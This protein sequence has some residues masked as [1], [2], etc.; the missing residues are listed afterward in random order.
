MA[1]RWGWAKALTQLAAL[2][3]WAVFI[4]IL[5][6]TNIVSKVNGYGSLCFLEE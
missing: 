1:I 4:A 2:F 3:T 5:D 6:F